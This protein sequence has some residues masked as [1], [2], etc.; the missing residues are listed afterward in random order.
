MIQKE[1]ETERMVLRVS[2]PSLAKRV[3]AFYQRN[4]EF[5]KDSE[6][7][8]EKHFYTDDFQ[9]KALARDYKQARE[10]CA[11]RLWM[12]PK[13]DPENGEVIGAVGLGGIAYGA[14]RSAFL[15]YQLDG[16]K[17]GQGYMHEG[18]SRLID[19]AFQDIGL[20][21]LEA[22][23]MPRNAASLRLVKKLG[24]HEEGLGVRFLKIGGAWE[25]HLR[26][27]LLHEEE[28]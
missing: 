7:D 14:F 6:P 16:S 27:A 9:R 10:L 24:F 15:R 11:L 5:L 18:L 3:S 4:R 20:H 1:Y 25:D 19:I 13:D 22:N 12:L 17:T 8:R 21:R 26:M 2:E 28:A 23:I